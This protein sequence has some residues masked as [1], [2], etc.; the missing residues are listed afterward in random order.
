MSESS[1]DLINVGTICG[2]FGVKGWVK[3]KSFTQPESNL[4]GFE[5]LFLKTKH[6]VKPC[7]FLEVEK[8]PKG[9]IALLDG[10]PD[11]TAAEKLGTITIATDKSALPELGENDFYWHDLI[12]LRVVSVFD[13][14][15]KQ[16]LGVVSSLMETGANDVLCVKPSATSID[17]QERLVPY[18]LETYVLNVDIQDGVIEVDWDPDF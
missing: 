15:Q 16:D 9:F 7:K 10:V 4:F 6:G 2:V 8:K 17:T 18:V 14:S 5:S 3:V 1:S 12:G 11:R 13:R